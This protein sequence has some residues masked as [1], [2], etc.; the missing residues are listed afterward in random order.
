MAEHVSDQEE[1]EAVLS[2]GLRRQYMQHVECLQC[3]RRSEPVIE[4]LLGFCLSTTR[5]FVSLLPG[6]FL[7][8]C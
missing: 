1:D 3:T 7:T 8:S 6:R 4:A 5:G 2:V